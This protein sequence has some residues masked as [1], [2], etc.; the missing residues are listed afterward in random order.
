MP[1]A[2]DALLLVLLMAESALV[3]HSCSAAEGEAMGFAA[4]VPA[5]LDGR[6]ER[7]GSAV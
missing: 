4:R 7:V 5:E 6:M 3:Q 2:G 1:R